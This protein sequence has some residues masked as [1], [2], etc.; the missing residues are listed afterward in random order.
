MGA[1]VAIYNLYAGV[2]LDMIHLRI[3]GIGVNI[4]FHPMHGLGLAAMPGRL[5]DYPSA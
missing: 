4:I 5:L 3:F 2:I 1:V